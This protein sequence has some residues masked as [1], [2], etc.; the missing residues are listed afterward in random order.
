M[1]VTL[2]ACKV[3]MLRVHELSNLRA[4]GLYGA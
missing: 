1:P 3:I 2:R 4:G